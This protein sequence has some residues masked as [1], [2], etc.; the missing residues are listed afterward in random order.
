MSITISLKKGL[1]LKLA[2]ELE[3]KEP[4]TIQTSTCAIV[5]DDF[6]GI[7]PKMEV[8][9]GDKVL[10]GTPVVRDKN[11]ETVKVVSTVSG[12]VK[13]VVRGE[14]RKIERVVID[15]EGNDKVK[16]DVTEKPLDLLLKSGL[17]A[18]MRQRPYDIVPNPEVMPRDI[19][20]TA[21]DSAPLALD[22]PTYV[23]GKEKE[24]AAGVKLLKSLTKGQVYVSARPGALND[25]PGA[26][27]VSVS[28]PHPAGNVGVQ[29]ANVSPVNKGEVVWTLNVVTLAKIG[30]LV[31]TGNLDETTLVALTGS[32][33][34]VPVI[35]KTVNGASIDAI[36]ASRL[37][38]TGAHQ[39]II[40]GNVLTGYK[41]STEGYLRFPYRQVTV[42]P[43]GDDVAE[44]MGWASL[45]SKKMSTSRSFPGH[46][47]SK[48]FTPDAR[49][50]GGRR[51]MITS[52]DYDKVLPM[53][54]LAEYLLKAIISKD[55]DKMEQLGIYEVA[56]EDFALPEYVDVSKQEL[57]K[58]VREGL[59]YLR[60]ELG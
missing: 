8:K 45:S 22:L 15:V 24:L 59:D 6:S 9:E 13:A 33:V 2:G 42:I 52:G 38:N 43:E 4:V 57:Q 27:M 19:F 34:D 11:H 5:P 28:G 60:A 55:I 36:V 17:F 54:I 23:A 40:S 48:V 35:V 18:E 49:I 50:L 25:I 53:D 29:I 41:V 20:V 51:A 32:E 30:T 47:L 1:D 58:L 10:V 31:L 56:P 14:R 44:F 7:T 3:S 12:T 37:K 39:R 16:F 46:F 26:E 21:I